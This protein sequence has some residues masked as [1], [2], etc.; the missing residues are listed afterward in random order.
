MEGGCGGERR[1]ER[2]AWEV[3]MACLEGELQVDSSGGWFVFVLACMD[4]GWMVEVVVCLEYWMVREVD[5]GVACWVSGRRECYR[6]VVVS[7][8]E[9]WMA[10]GLEGW[11][12]GGRTSG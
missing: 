12:G 2:L 7:C 8:L 6:E 1:W 5:V 11:K 4:D 9:E 3:H 10:R